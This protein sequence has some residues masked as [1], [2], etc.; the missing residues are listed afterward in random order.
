[1]SL[2]STE[3]SLPLGAEQANLERVLILHACRTLSTVL[4][5]FFVDIVSHCVM[6]KFVRG[7]AQRAELMSSYGFVFML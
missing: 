5:S 7:D 3:H 1:M 6:N 2:L 4:L